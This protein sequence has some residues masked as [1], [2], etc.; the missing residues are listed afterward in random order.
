MAETQ[1]LDIKTTTR[2]EMIDITSL[3]RSAIRESGVESGIAVVFCPHTTAGL[4]LQENSDPSVKS[5]LLRQLEKLVPRDGGYDHSEDNQDAHIKS[6]IIGASISLIV[7]KGKPVL[8]HW[9]A[10]F[11]CEFDGP[12][13]RGVMVRTVGD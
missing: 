9:Q 2:N 13:R 8:G 7:D 1:F 12:R 4:S 3:V 5:D 10:L 11:F 6:S